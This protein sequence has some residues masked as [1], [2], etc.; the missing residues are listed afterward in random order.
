MASSLPTIERTLA[1]LEVHLGVRL[2]NRSTRRISLTKKGCRHL[3]SCRQVLAALNDAEAALTAEAGEPAG[4]LSISAPMLF[5]QMHVA[6][7][8][9]RFVQE[10]T[11]MR[12]SVVLLDRVVNLLEEGIHVGIRI[13]QLEDSSWSRSR[14][15]A[16]GVWWWP[17]RLFCAGT[18]CLRTPKRCFRPTACA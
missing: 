12:C 5:G 14:S 16:Y 6:P 8:V 10:Y 15:A 18:A 2:F 3:D 17:A 11:Q 7:A 9:T 1:V 4:H 13:G